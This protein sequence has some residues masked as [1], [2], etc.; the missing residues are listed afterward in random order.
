LRDISQAGVKSPDAQP[1]NRLN[2]GF[3]VGIQHAQNPNIGGSMLR[4]D[5][6]IRP[7][8]TIRDVKVQHP[9]TSLIFER[10]GFREVCD[11]CAIGIVAQRQGI[12]V[13][14]VIDE[15]NSALTAAAGSPE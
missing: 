9:W 10:F 2:S 15:L 11:D 14:E 4:F 5:R 7:S 3:P 6:L 12:A 13:F 8:M 1:E